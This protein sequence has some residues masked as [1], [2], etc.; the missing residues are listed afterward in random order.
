MSMIYELISFSEAFGT[1]S[2]LVEAV[3]GIYVFSALSVSVHPSM[4]RMNGLSR[5]RVHGIAPGNAGYGAILVRSIS[6]RHNSDA[7]GGCVPVS[8]PQ[9]LPD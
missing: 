9:N 4:R 7:A 6:D 1:Q 2:E 8:S 5:E 3:P